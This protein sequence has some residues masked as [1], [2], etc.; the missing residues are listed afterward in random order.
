MTL[1]EVGPRD[2]LQDLSPP[3][4]TADKIAFIDRLSEAG[5]PV[6]EVGAFVHPRRVPAMADTEAVAVGIARRPGTRYTALVPNL[7]GLARA[8]GAGLREVSVFG[9][10]SEAFS[11]HNI[12]HGIA[13][14]FARFNDVI[15]EAGAARGRGARVPL[16][17]IRLPLRRRCPR[18]PRR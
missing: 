5:V 3:P 7:R 2:G 10:T 4:R 18:R 9:A 15:R 8:I 6:I 17:G 12:N 16:H 11:L 1:V 13:D 14:A